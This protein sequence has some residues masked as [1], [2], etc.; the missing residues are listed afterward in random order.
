M[1]LT[2]IAA[3]LLSIVVAQ[4]VPEGPIVIGMDDTIERRW[5]RALRRGYLPRSGPLQSWTF[6]QSQWVALAELYGSFSC[7]MGAMRQGI[8]GIDAAVSV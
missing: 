1:E 8:A 5:G 4:L 6:R 2:I 7:S 3:R